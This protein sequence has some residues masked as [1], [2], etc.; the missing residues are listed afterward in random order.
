MIRPKE[1]SEG[2]GGNRKLRDTAKRR[3]FNGNIVIMAVL[4]INNIY[5]NNEKI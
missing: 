1:R 2:G 5:I 4:N 3:F